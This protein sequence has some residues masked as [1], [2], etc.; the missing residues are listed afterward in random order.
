MFAGRLD[1]R[2]LTITAILVTANL[3]VCIHRSSRVYLF[4]QSL[5]LQYYLATDVEKVS[6]QWSVAEDLCRIKEVQSTLSMIEGADAFLQLLPGQYPHCFQRIS[7]AEGSLI[8]VR[9]PALLMLATFQK[10]L[11]IV[12]LRRCLLVNVAFSGAGI[13]LSIFF[14]KLPCLRLEF[15]LIEV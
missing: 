13:V 1:L 4:Q 7:L 11:P 5:C 9:F 3:A 12:G 14:C 2:V 8:V 10:L 15:P 6:S